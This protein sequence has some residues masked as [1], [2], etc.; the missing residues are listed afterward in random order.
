M[1]VVELVFMVVGFTIAS[2]SI[3][4]NDAIQTLGTFLASNGKRPWWVLWAFAVGVLTAVMAWGYFTSP[5]TTA[6]WTSDVT[7]EQAG[8]VTVAENVDWLSIHPWSNI[9]AEGIHAASPSSS[10]IQFKRADGDASS[11]LSFIQSA[12]LVLVTEEKKAVVIAT[13]S[14]AGEGGKRLTFEPTE[15]DLT[16]IAKSGRSSLLLRVSGAPASPTQVSIK[17]GL[18]ADVSWFNYHGDISYGRLEKY[19]LPQPFT[20]IYVIPPIALLFLTRGGFPVSTTFLIL[21]VFQAK[22]LPDMLIKSLSGYAF[23]FVIAV[24][25][26]LGITKVVE[27]RFMKTKADE[28]SVGWVIAQWATTAFLWGQWLIQDLANIFVYLPR[29]LSLS[30]L[31]F[32]FV[33]MLLLHAY[34][35]YTAGGEIQKIVTSKTNATDIRSAALINLMFGIVLL[36]FKE[37]SNMPMSTTWVFLGLLAGREIAMNVRLKARDWRELLRMVGSDGLKASVGLV[38]SVVI[39]I[40]LPWLATQVETTVASFD[41]QETEQ[42]TPTTAATV[43][44]KLP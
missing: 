31:A 1:G 26:Y 23:A 14:P 27:E 39:A 40:G 41:V 11:D 13:A 4:G 35:F 7:I 30:W 38:V 19:P 33:V 9:G 20:W 36:V 37:W 25:V 15:A 10:S 8:E 28:P 34:I 24:V 3:V 29:A 6:Q 44:P 43:L 42:A 16:T 17:T 22:N 21:T 12:E 5:N 18:H 2:Y 32:A